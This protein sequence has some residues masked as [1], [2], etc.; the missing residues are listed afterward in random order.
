MH[1]AHYITQIVATGLILPWALDFTPDGR[2]FLTERVGR[3]RVVQEG[4]LLPEPLI[5]FSDPFVSIGEGGLLGLAVDPNFDENH[6]LYVY[7][8]Y[9]EEGQLRNRVVRLVERDNKATIDQ[10]LISDIP[11]NQVHNG[12]RI[13]IGPDGFLY[14]TTGDAAVPSSAQIRSVLSGKIL[15]IRLDGSIPSSNPFLDSPV[16]SLGHRNPQGLA[17]DPRTDNLY[18]SEHGPV[19]HDEINLIRPGLNYGWPIITGDQRRNGLQTPIIQSGNVTWAPSGMTFVSRGPWR[20]QLL[21]ANLRG[22]QILR[23]FIHPRNP[24]SIR[25]ISAF[26]QSHGR[27]R[28]VVEGP[29]GSL[30]VLTSNTGGQVRPGD[31]KLFRL[32]PKRG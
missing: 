13:K 25:L 15:C 26:F 11:G 10:I 9:Q 20:G 7:H 1:L 17:W 21:V 27:I 30:Y 8:S 18:S 14:I 6:F 19:A 24:R 29:D 22:S 31:D 16:Y 4:K 2:I 32:I 12:G 28:D 23:F 3:I 5:T